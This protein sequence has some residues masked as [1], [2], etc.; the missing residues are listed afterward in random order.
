MNFDWTSSEDLW[1]PQTCQIFFSE[2]C[3]WV[4]TSG[5]LSSKTVAITKRSM[6]LAAESVCKEFSIS[7]KDKWLSPISSKHI[8]GLSISCRCF[9]SGCEHLHWTSK[10]AFQAQNFWTHLNR[11]KATI[12]SLT[13]THLFDMIKLEK[14]APKSLRLAFV[15][16]GF[17][18]LSIYKKALALKWPIVLSYG[19]TESGSMIAIARPLEG[20]CYQSVSQL[21]L[22]KP[23]A[24]VRW[25]CCEQTKTLQLFSE[26]L[27]E[28]YW[29][30][31]KF[32]SRLEGWF[33]TEDLCEA[34]AE[35]FRILGRKSQVQKV[36][37]HFV[38][39]NDLK[40]LW[41][42]R[43]FRSRVEFCFDKNERSSLWVSLICELDT[44][45]EK[46]DLKFQVKSFNKD[47]KAFERVR[48]IYYLDEIPKTLLYKVKS[49][50]LK[51][52]LGL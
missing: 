49:E 2:P 7:K 30:R 9:V 4:S 41:N 19:L 33:D 12:T 3:V 20:A 23:L 26:A 27:F 44:L 34:E 43:G 18:S 16:G 25:M 15:G 40:E 13:P 24:H 6:I 1:R 39:L 52:R 37:G 29:V 10:E 22:L 45:N 21:P 38:N 32:H 51:K 11:K 36:K 17:L 46:K 47:L 14:P 31:E 28:G 48:V 42:S 5:S 35:G 8:G 50:D